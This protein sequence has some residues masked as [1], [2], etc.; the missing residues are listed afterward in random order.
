MTLCEC[1]CGQPAPIAGQTDLK[2]GY[3]KGEP[4]RFVKGHQR[5][6]KRAIADRFAAK[7]DLNG[8][9]PECAPELGQCHLWTAG[10]MG[11]G[12]GCIWDDVRG[13]MV[14]A[15]IVAYEMAEGHAVPDGYELDH[16]C[17][18]RRCVRP[19][20]LETVTHRENVVRG[21]RPRMTREQR[22]ERNPAAK[23][24]APQVAEIRQMYASGDVT[25][26]ALG[27]KFGVTTRTIGNIVRGAS[28]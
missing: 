24:R 27:R 20:H 4:R 14:G 3:V 11:K 9:V 8:P 10:L 6:P 21:V 16:L 25:Q 23:L 22:G 18:V 28:W 5:K 19:S 26:T 2:R 17:R 13:R 12:Y 15:H 1:G 7:V